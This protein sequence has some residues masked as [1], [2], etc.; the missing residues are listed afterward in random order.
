M[1][2]DD[3]QFEPGGFEPFRQFRLLFALKQQLR[4]LSMQELRQR[5]GGEYVEGDERGKTT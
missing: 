2:I 3:F 5:E 1:A 4:D